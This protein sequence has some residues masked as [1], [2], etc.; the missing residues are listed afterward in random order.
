MV[1]F[2]DDR[3]PDKISYGSS[4][5]PRFRTNIFAMDSGRV[6]GYSEWDQVKA[7]YEVTMDYV[8]EADINALVDHFYMCRAAAIGF[9]FKDWLDYK[10]TNQNF[11]VGDGTT[12][13]FQL[14]KR[15]KSE[16]FKYDRT[17]KKLVSGTLGTV[18]VGASTKT[19]GVDF[20]V[21]Y[22]TGIFT[23]N[24]APA[25]SEVGRVAYCEF[26]VP[27]RYDTDYLPI[28]CFVHRMYSISSLPIVEIL[29]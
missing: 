1:D 14:F 2:I 18:T 5:G 12:T 24:V 29:I 4:G 7:S 22:D 25:K 28:Q 13:D 11:F 23:F 16:Q 26:D 3:F 10:V 20:T 6:A 19:E 15:Y 8:A 21:D 9:R 17:L 27:C